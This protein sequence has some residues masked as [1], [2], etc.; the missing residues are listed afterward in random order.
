MRYLRC[1]LE[2]LLGLLGIPPFYA[3]LKTTLNHFMI[4]TSR[5]LKICL[6]IF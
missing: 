1:L 2:L 4:K 5:K 6:L 3:A